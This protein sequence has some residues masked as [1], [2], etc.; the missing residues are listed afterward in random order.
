[1]K[2]NISTAKFGEGTRVRLWIALNVFPILVG[3]SP[4]LSPFP[5]CPRTMNNLPY[6]IIQH[7]ILHSRNAVLFSVLVL[8]A[9]YTPHSLSALLRGPFYGPLL[10]LISSLL[11]L[12]QVSLVADLPRPICTF[13]LPFDCM[14]ASNPFASTQEMDLREKKL[15]SFF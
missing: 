10:S 5:V 8:V 12:Q 15:S 13:F 7:H 2:S 1:M 6:A 14:L 9:V 11:F 4:S 3:P